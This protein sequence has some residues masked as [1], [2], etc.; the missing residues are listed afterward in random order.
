MDEKLRNK[1]FL[2]I[3]NIYIFFACIAVVILLGYLAFSNHN[4]PMLVILLQFLMIVFLI[5]FIAGN[6]C[7]NG[8]FW[9][10]FSYVLYHNSVVFSKNRDSDSF[11]ADY[12]MVRRI[13][14]NIDGLKHMS[15]CLSKSEVSLPVRLKGNIEL[16]DFIRDKG[17]VSI[18]KPVKSDH[19]SIEFQ[20][21]FDPPLMKN[22]AASYVLKFR[23]ENLYDKNS[24]HIEKFAHSGDSE[25][26][27]L[28]IHRRIQD[29][30]FDIRFNNN[31]MV[32]I[33]GCDVTRGDAGTDFESEQKF[34]ENN[35]CFRVIDD[36]E[37]QLISF[38]RT[39]P[40]VGARYTFR[41]KP[42]KQDQ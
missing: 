1:L 38:A 9:E 33:L 29:C 2:S 6:C 20:V 8:C 3:R 39:R 18:D 17:T 31:C 27:S 12:N 36:A 30:G 37:G 22:E 42:I 13:K 35:R 14:S 7:R 34:V 11:C 24:E 26:N 5:G 41:W 21:N 15:I 16:I 28:Y 32:D 40:P 19:M 23:A 10:D 25:F 4:F